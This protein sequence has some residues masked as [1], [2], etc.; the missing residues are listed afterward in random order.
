[1]LDSLRRWA[2]GWVAFI[3]ILLLILSF[4]IWGIADYVTGGGARPL[5]TIGGTKITADQ[6]QQAFQ[7]EI[8]ELSQRAGQRISFDQARA[9]GLDGQVMSQLIGSAAVEAHADELGLALS[10]AAIAE[11]LKRDPSFQGP[12]GKFS[13]QQLDDV[14]RQLGLSEAG[15]VAL[16]RKDELRKHI[17]SALLRSTV[18]PE[19]L[20]DK[21]HAHRNET[22]VVEFARLDPAKA[23][24][25][26]EPSEDDLKAFYEVG[27]ARYRTEPQRHLQALVLP[28]AELGRRAPIDE[29]AIR[30]AYDQ[31]RSEYDVPERRAIEQIAFKDRAAADRARAEI[32]AGKDFLEVAKANGATEADVALGTLTRDQMIDKAIAEVAFALEKDA[33]SDVVAGRFTTVILRVREIVAGKQ[34][35][36]EEVK[37]KVRARLAVEWARAE[38][39]RLYNEVDDGRAAGTPLAEISQK[40]QIPYY[41]IPAVSRTNKTEDG[42]IVLDIVDGDSIIAAGFAGEPGLEGEAVSLS[43]GSTAWV[44]VVSVTAAEQKSFES[45]RESVKA[46]W[47]AER[48][49]TLLSERAAALAERL[50]AGGDFA[51]LAGEVG[52]TVTKAPPA[53]RTTVPEG[54]TQAAVAQAFALPKDGIG[55]AET[56][57]GTSRLVLRVVEIRPPSELTTEQRDALRREL[58]QEQRSDEI[59][60]YLAALQKRLGLTI[61]QAALDRLMG[62][63]AQ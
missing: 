52:G 13:K 9:I 30:T 37:D 24:V 63:E 27:K 48:R 25:L 22:R 58:A 61:D 21:L 23:I 14:M 62:G 5:A 32:A 26:P 40:L 57:D 54:L 38:A 2:S 59:G 60:V 41:D 34:S 18:V 8:S 19:P 46:D 1:M 7:N 53:T 43:D 42:R 55:H 28:I 56:L 33:V 49:R 51:T 39:Q 20:I 31:T 17:T 45:A 12:D 11:G 36:F 3:M 35:A 4:A 44:D 15:L 6:F 16:R 50:R 29:A 47:T 10:D